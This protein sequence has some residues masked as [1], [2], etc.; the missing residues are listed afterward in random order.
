[1]VPDPEDEPGGFPPGELAVAVAAAANPT[2]ED[3]RRF[4]DRCRRAVQLA[5]GV[6][7]LLREYTSRCS[8]R[9]RGHAKILAAAGKRVELADNSKHLLA[10][11]AR[12]DRL[13]KVGSTLSGAREQLAVLKRTQERGQTTSGYT[14]SQLLDRVFTPPEVDRAKYLLRRLHSRGLSE[15]VVF[16]DT[17]PEGNEEQVEVY[18]NFI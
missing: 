18:R 7:L 9:V 13:E 10:Q 6:S 16:L 4:V 8:A 5:P 1:M 12:L 15:D 11:E 14:A 3:I 17:Y 2:D